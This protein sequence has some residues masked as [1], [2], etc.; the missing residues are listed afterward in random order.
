MTNQPPS[1]R[2][3]RRG[4]LTVAPLAF[5]M[6]A[7]CGPGCAPPSAPTEGSE[8]RAPDDRTAK[9]AAGDAAKPGAPATADAATR[10]APGVDLSKLDAGQRRAFFQLIDTEPSACD[11]PHSLATSLAEDGACRDSM[12][13]AQYVADRLASG[14]TLGDVKEEAVGIAGVL[15]VKEIP[16]EGR[17]VFGNP[18]APVTVV[19]FADFECPHC[20]AEAPVLRQAVQQFRGQARLVYKHYPLNMHPRAKRAAVAA[21]AAL[22]QGKFWEMHDQIFAH[23]DALEDEDLERY[24]KAIGLDMA[25]YAAHF[26]A[27]RGLS[28][29]EGDRKDGDTLGFTGTPAVFINGRQY[30]PAL[31]GGTVEGWIDDALRR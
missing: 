13:I 3:F 19:V 23:Q 11:K 15:K 5:A 28:A 22:A 7:T 20:R 27:E 30:T 12:I 17:P 21:E 25:A 14:G 4:R 16:T 6:F 26:G 29:V 31:F 2:R 1:S 10:E 9:P 24:A 8:R 18:R